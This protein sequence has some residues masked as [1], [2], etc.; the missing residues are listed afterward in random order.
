MVNNSTNLKKQQTIMSRL[1]LL[2]K[3]SLSTD[4]QQFH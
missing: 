2:W 4:G 3:E 1:K